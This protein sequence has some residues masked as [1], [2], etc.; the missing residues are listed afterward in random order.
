MARTAA[1]DSASA[2][3]NKSYRIVLSPMAEWIRPCLEC[4]CVKMSNDFIK[5]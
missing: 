3:L 2:E 4:K 1:T 5:N